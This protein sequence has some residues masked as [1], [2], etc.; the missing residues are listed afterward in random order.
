MG[1][2]GEE[3]ALRWDCGGCSC[4]S[5]CSMGSSSGGTVGRGALG[6]VVFEVLRFRV[7]GEEG[8]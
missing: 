7:E 1:E 4:S 8:G 6:S 3:Q 5:I 2:S